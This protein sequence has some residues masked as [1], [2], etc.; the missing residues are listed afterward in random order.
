MING[1]KNGPRECDCF[2]GTILMAMGRMVTKVAEMEV[3]EA[4]ERFELGSVNDPA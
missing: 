3:R 1:Q 4:F 2:C